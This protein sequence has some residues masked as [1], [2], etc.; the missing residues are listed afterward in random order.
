MQLDEL[1]RERQPE[2]GALPRFREPATELLKLVEDP[3]LILGRDPDPAVLHG[4]LQLPAH[5]PSGYIYS[6]AGRREL[7]RVGQQVEEHLLELA[8]IGFHDSQRRLNVSG[9][10]GTL[11]LS[12]RA[13]HGHAVLYS[14]RKPERARFELHATRLDLG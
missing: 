12:T 3:L 14:A 1:L 6:A 7:H 13:N 8:F 2:P 4:Y 9:H 10:L 11:P 5:A